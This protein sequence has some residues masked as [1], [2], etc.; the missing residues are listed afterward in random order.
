MGDIEHDDAKLSRRDVFGLGSGGS[1]RQHHDGERE[2]G[3]R[4]ADGWPHCAKRD[5]SRT[6]K[7]A[8][9]GGESG[10]R[11]VSIHR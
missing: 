8:S 9:G 5:R 1:R 10:F 7:P 6:P 2:N 3:G 4:A 11:M